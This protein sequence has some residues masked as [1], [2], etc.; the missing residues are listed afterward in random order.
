MPRILF[1]AGH[2]QSYLLYFLDCDRFKC[3][4]G[5]HRIAEQFGVKPSYLACF[6]CQFRD[7]IGWRGARNDASGARFPLPL[8][9]VVNH[10]DV[11]TAL[12]APQCQFGVAV[13]L[14]SI[15]ESTARRSN[16][17]ACEADRFTR[18]LLQCEGFHIVIG[19][20]IVS[21]SFVNDLRS[22]Q[23]YSEGQSYLNDAPNFLELM[24]CPAIVQRH[25]A[26]VV[27][28]GDMPDMIGWD[29]GQIVDLDSSAIL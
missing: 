29:R 12:G 28:Y 1:D 4:V 5:R 25:I 21:F 23:P 15:L 19:T 13:L 10:Q 26:V 2:E 16:L 20:H 7:H 9:G 24:I 14:A 8:R 22:A 11:L 18:R 27:H 3:L 6:V 17:H